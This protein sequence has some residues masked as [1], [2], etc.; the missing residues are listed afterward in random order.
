MIDLLILVS[1]RFQMCGE[2][3]YNEQ[4]DRKSYPRTTVEGIV[5]GVSRKNI[6]I[7]ALEKKPVAATYPTHRRLSQGLCSY[8]ASDPIA[9]TV[10]DLKPG[11]RVTLYLCEEGK[12][13]YCFALSINR[14]PGG[15]IPQSRHP[16]IFHPYADESN[17][18]NAF[19][20]SGTIIPKYLTCKAPGEYPFADPEIAKGK[21]LAKWPKSDPFSYI[22]FALF[23]R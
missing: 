15:L 23:L 4:Y 19:K 10:H 20:D 22:E 5:L 7:Q 17:A 3:L 16:E 1:M 21:R 6:E 9:Y 11:D 8:R 12:R 13:E 18:L 2:L 14:R